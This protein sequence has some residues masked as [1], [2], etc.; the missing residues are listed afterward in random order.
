MNTNQQRHVS[1][2][3]ALAAENQGRGADSSEEASPSSPQDWE[4]FFPEFGE[5]FKKCAFLF[6]VSGVVE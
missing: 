5:H 6:E 2:T 4:L 3:T 1:C